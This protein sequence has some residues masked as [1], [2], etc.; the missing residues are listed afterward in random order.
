MVVGLGCC[1]VLG[2][3]V[4]GL[5]GRLERDA[6]AVR[7][8]GEVGQERSERAVRLLGVFSLVGVV[9][10]IPVAGMCV[11]CGMRECVRELSL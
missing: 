5:L 4:V 7:W 6:V 3:P 2:L 11:G 1:T 9:R 8:A 10:V